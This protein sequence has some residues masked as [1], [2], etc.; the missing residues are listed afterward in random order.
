MKKD[1]LKQIEQSMELAYKNAMKIIEVEN[2]Q[3][4]FSYPIVFGAKMQ[5]CNN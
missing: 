3:K 2:K 4:P 1:I 5:I